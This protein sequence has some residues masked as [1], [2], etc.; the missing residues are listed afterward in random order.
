MW[1]SQ[2]TESDAFIKLSP[3]AIKVL[4]RFHQKTHRK[5]PRGGKRKRLN[6][7]DIVNPGQLV[8]TYAEARYLKISKSAFARALKQLIELGFI[9]ITEQGSHY[10]NKPTK[11]GISDVWKKYGTESWV[12]IEKKRVLGDGIGFQPKKRQKK[13][14]SK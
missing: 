12:P 7:S 13:G 4:L 6:D 11:F 1:D 10:G 8:F 9:V 14:G 5:V 3:T 2:I